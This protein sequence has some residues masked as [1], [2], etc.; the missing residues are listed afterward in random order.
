MA[1]ILVIDDDFEILRFIKTT[2]ERQGHRVMTE[3]CTL[4]VTHEKLRFA[5][6][7]LLDIMMPEENGFE[8]LKRIRQIVDAPILFVT[9]KNSETDLI[10]GLGL[11][12]D[13]YIEKPFSVGELRARVSAHLRRESREHIHAI[14]MGDLFL[15]FDFKEISYNDTPLAL[16][17]SEYSIC[18]FL[19][20]NAGHTFSKGQIYE[21]IFGYDGVSDESVIVEHIKN[22]R[23]KLKAYSLDPI[24]TIWGVGYRWQKEKQ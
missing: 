17:K 15:N 3:H 11:G 4:K 5:D 12:A 21:S 24:I 7:I 1:E 2:L 13:D 22:I 20:K 18:A 10:Y 9:A 14:K 19:I 8:Y 6:L 16:T 23:R